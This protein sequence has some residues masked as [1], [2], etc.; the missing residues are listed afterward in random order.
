M[1][2]LKNALVATLLSALPVHAG[3]SAFA[4]SSAT[5][6]VCN[7]GCAHTTVQAAINAASPGD[8]IEIAAGTYTE[9]LTL[10]KPVTL[11]GGFVTAPAW[12]AGPAGSISVIRG[13]NARSVL[14]IAGADTLPIG[15]TLRRLRVENGR[16]TPRGGGINARFVDLNVAE[17]IIAGN[18]TTAT[19][20]NDQAYGGGLYLE[21]GTLSL[22]QTRFENNI[23]DCAG[24]Y[25]PVTNGGA[26]FITGTLS[27]TINNCE[28][29][30]NIGWVGAAI[31]GENSM[32]HIRNSSVSNNRGAYGA[33]V[34]AMNSVVT[35]TASSFVGNASGQGGVLRAIGGAQAT[36]ERN[37]L[38]NNTSGQAIVETFND[39]RLALINNVLL[40]N[41]L[42]FSQTGSALIAVGSRQSFVAH[43]TIAN[44]KLREPSTQPLLFLRGI[45]TQTLAN[46]ILISATLGISASASVTYELSNTIMHRIA[47][48][49]GGTAPVIS[50]SLLIANPLLRNE[51]NDARLSAG[52]PAINAGIALPS[53]TNDLTN[54]AR[55]TQ[56]DIGAYEFAAGGAA[57]R[58]IF[59]PLVAR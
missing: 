26:L 20:A 48:P 53:V 34:D 11:S 27:A 55:D 15:V 6:R 35:V 12:A 36:F 10:A 3:S 24:L 32:L 22:D 59:L 8:V 56:P 33:G 58:V 57:D 5:I 50:A 40:G 1:K 21:A 41:S 42:T 18:T 28:F 52:S 31:A 39:D 9:T 45:E 2:T 14:S 13:D 16:G 25:C 46:N 49:V 44:T 37:T 30:D 7:T 47:T 43:N 17:S 38:L 29:I 51:S 4:A 23:V 19:V 54:S